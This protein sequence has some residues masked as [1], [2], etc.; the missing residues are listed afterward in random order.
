MNCCEDLAGAIREEG[1]LQKGKDI[2]DL[3]FR[4]VRRYEYALREGL[5]PSKERE[6]FISRIVGDILVKLSGKRIN[7]TENLKCAASRILGMLSGIGGDYLTLCALYFQLRKLE[8]RE[9]DGLIELVRR[10]SQC[11]G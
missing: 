5:D 6:A 1:I 9:I 4:L 11:R 7:S 10:A 3:A 8:K 2:Y